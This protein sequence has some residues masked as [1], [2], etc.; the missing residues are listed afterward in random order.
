QPAGPGRSAAPA[1]VVVVGGDCGGGGVVVVFCLFF[2]SSFFFFPA[3]RL[4]VFLL[5]PSAHEQAASL[6]P[7]G[8]SIPD[9]PAGPKAGACARADTPDWD[10]E[11]GRP[12]APQMVKPL[13]PPLSC[14]R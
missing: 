8:T 5:R 7:G 3:S 4:A 9:G 10:R 6:H 11:V 13:T 2:V 14:M 12:A 1:R